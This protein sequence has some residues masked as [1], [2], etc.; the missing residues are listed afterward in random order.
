[1]GLSIF[2]STTSSLLL[3]DGKTSQM[4]NDVLEKH[5]LFLIE[6]HQVGML[7]DKYVERKTSL[8]EEYTAVLSSPELSE[9]LDINKIN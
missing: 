2:Q 1:M 5:L 8:L 4:L 3:F 9:Y 7:Y 6:M